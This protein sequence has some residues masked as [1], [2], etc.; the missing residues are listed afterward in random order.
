MFYPKGTELLLRS[1]GYCCVGGLA[2]GEDRQSS[3]CIKELS[4]KMWMTYSF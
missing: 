2:A 3:V 4:V 1:D